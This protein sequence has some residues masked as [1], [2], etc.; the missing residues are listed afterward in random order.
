[1]ARLT[2]AL[3]LVLA[4]VAAAPA[5]AI[6][7]Q[8]PVRVDRYVPMKVPPGPGPA[9]YDRVFVKQ[10]GP[11]AARNVLVL[12]PGT[13]GGAGGIVPVARDIVRRV[14]ETQ[15]WIVDRR[16]QAL[17]D[18][19]V[20]ATRDPQRAQDYYLGFQYKRV[21]G[22][23]AKFAANWGLKLQLA[24]LRS[25][26]RRAR[27]GG[28]RV[29]LGGHSA[30][31]S[32]AVAYAAWDFRGRPGYR[33]LDGLV[34]IDGGLLGSF[35]SANLARAKRELADIRTGKVFLDLL[36]TGLP[37]ING[38]F[39]QVGALW[40]YKRPDEPSVLQ[41]Y[42]LLPDFLKPEVRVTNEAAFGYAFDET[43]SPDSLALIQIRAG[44][45]AGSGDP[46]GWQDGEITPIQRHARAYAADHPNATEWYYPRRLLLDFDAASPMRQTPAA[47]FLGLRL[48][49]GS[50]IDL[51]LYAFSTALT[52]GR[53]ARGAKRLVNRS[54]IEEFRIV[55]DRGTSHLDP[56]SA[57]PRRND[58]LKSVAPFLKRHTR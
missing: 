40:A 44:R 20:F 43:T 49:H 32:T 3:S 45:L 5:T 56:L 6:D 8:P 15:V 47:K 51:P 18:T 54:K 27:T 33:D 17:E 38:I 12:V 10:L 35:A 53:V 48:M 2:L 22:E 57:A 25:V 58:F 42:P 41:E 26:I 13:N 28:R 39:A 50:E 52:R 31:A 14:P 30:G 19:S 29:F 4:L 11:L 24:D 34:L 7:A 37:E 9:K 46:R 1:M 23:D 21:A 36:G 16:E 55:D